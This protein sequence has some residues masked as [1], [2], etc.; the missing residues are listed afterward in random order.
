MNIND[1][2]YRW[3][4]AALLG[5]ATPIDVNEPAAGFY[6][7]ARSNLPYAYW[8]ENSKQRCHINGHDVELQ[9]ALDD[10]PYV[11]KNPVSHEDYKHRIATGLWLSEHEA[12]HNHNRAP[13]E[14]SVEALKDR[15][16]VLARNAQALID[17]GEAKTQ[18]SCD[19][20]AEL[21]NTL[22]ELENKVRA[23]H[24]AQKQPHLIMGRE[25][26]RRWFPLR[27][28]AAEFK[29]K[30]KQ[31]VITPFLKKTGGGAGLTK[32]TVALVSNYRAE[33]VDMALLM[34][35]LQNNPDVIALLQRLANRA[36]NSKV[37]LPGTRL[38]VEQRAA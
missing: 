1:N 31:I 9:R 32:R 22:G 7:N 23:L 14:D 8:V 26:D 12:V 25:I 13:S 33:I 17:A 36:A 11:A 20:A 2:D 4:A 27:D 6:R 18:H 16:D 24:D 34:Q 30:V 5:H 28:K 37:E 21:A 38:I 10:W 3:W 29:T 35:C 15:I 19:Q